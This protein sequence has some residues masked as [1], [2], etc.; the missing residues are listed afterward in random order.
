[1]LVLKTIIALLYVVLIAI[2]SFIFLIIFY[3]IFPPY[4]PSPCPYAA[5]N[6]TNALIFTDKTTQDHPS[7]ALPYYFLPY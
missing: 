7:H 1:M 2:S 6:K 5:K 4:E 3:H